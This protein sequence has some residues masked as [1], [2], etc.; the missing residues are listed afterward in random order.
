MACGK[1]N[2]T[3]P[4]VTSVM[5]RSALDGDQEAREWIVR[6]LSPLLLAQAGHRMGPELRCH[7]TPED[8]VADVWQ[9]AL[10]RLTRELR[11]AA[12]RCTPLLVGFLSGVLINRAN[13]LL[14]KAIRIR[15][16]A[17]PCGDSASEPGVLR[18]PLR[19]PA[20]AV[21]RPL[22]VHDDVTKV[23]AL[24]DDLEPGDREII[25]LRKIEG[26]SA[27]EVA[28]QLK[29]AAYVIDKRLSRALARLRKQVPDG[30]FDELDDGG[31]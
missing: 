24:L 6:R 21:W 3:R 5:V 30:V 4:D 7:C 27:K 23:R 1:H 11:P 16:A 14:R 17:L 28:R 19:D 29:V 8:V 25:I 2:S 10:P 18:I 26:L 9:R 31:A 20:E 15:A 13:E 22:L 12:G